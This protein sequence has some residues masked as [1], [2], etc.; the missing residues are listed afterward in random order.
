VRHALD[1]IPG[2]TITRSWAN[3]DITLEEFGFDITTSG[4]RVLDLGFSESDPARGLSGKQLSNALT[5]RIERELQST[6]Q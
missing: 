1:R 4:G 5:A 3:D 6:N 2:V